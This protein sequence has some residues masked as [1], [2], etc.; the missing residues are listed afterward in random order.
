MTKFDIKNLYEDRFNFLEVIKQY[1]YK[2]EKIAEFAENIQKNINNCKEI[3]VQI[4]FKYLPKVIHY[5]NV[6]KMF[7]EEYKSI[8]PIE[9]AGIIKY[10]CCYT[11]PCEKMYNDIIIFDTNLKEIKRLNMEYTYHDACLFN[12]NNLAKTHILFKQNKNYSELY[13]V[14]DDVIIYIGE[15]LDDID[16]SNRYIYMHH[17]NKILI[18]AY[19]VQKEKFLDL[20][21]IAESDFYSVGVKHLNDFLFYI[22]VNFKNKFIS[23]ISNIRDNTLLELKHSAEI[24]YNNGVYTFKSIYTD[25]ILAVIDIEG[26][27]VLYKKF[28][29]N[30]EKKYNIIIKNTYYI[31]KIDNIEILGIDIKENML[32]K[33][34]YRYIIDGEE[35]EY[36]TDYHNDELLKKGYILFRFPY[37]KETDEITYEFYSF[38][39]KSFVSNLKI[40]QTEIENLISI[41][42]KIVKQ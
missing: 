28:N 27:P 21:K 15:I 31:D 20:L 17:N 18:Y 8:Q 3:F 7:S 9:V 14:D 35:I 6:Y 37:N 10:I 34:Y 5:E 11:Y 13:N 23:Y 12:N 36:I 42:N 38:E 40:K 39:R 32:D 22:D 26:T 19:D 33:K 30:I 41:L 1:E 16:E 24:Q 2:S 4:L 25:E 29:I